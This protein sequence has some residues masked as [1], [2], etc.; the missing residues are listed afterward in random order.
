MDEKDGKDLRVSKRGVRDIAHEVT[1]R[2]S[3][4]ACLRIA[5]QE[6]RRIQ[7]KVKLAKTVADRSGRE[8]VREEDLMVVENILDE[9]L[10]P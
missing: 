10:P 1:G 2:I 5:L 8:T 3:D 6:E 9:Q 4:E 7:K